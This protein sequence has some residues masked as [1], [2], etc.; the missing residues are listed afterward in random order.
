MFL[1]KS[2]VTAKCVILGRVLSVLRLIG[3]RTI[4]KIID[5]E[6]SESRYL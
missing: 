5:L 1:L 3:E 6:W 4:A 2:I